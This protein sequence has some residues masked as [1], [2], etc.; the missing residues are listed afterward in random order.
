MTREY[1]THFTNSYFR[2]LF[3]MAPAYVFYKLYFKQYYGG[4]LKLLLADLWE[5]AMVEVGIDED[6]DD[7]E[8]DY[9]NLE[10]INVDER[11][12]IILIYLP[13]P[14]APP[15]AW[16]IVLT[17]QHQDPG[18]DVFRYRYF[19]LEHR[20]GKNNDP[21]QVVCELEKESKKEHGELLSSEKDV[22]ISMVKKIIKN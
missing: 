12:D 13:K 19:T 15:E 17:R 21:L 7:D 2:K 6:M 22:F 8:F 3:F 10:R 16:Y 14:I 9:L 18:K 20:T 11:T 1:H 5:E 4:Y